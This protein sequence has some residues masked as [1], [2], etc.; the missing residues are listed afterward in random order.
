MT[1]ILQFYSPKFNQQVLI[2]PALKIFHSKAVAQILYA[3]KG[4][5]GIVDAA[6]K[7]DGQPF[8]FTFAPYV[9][10]SFDLSYKQI[11]LFSTSVDMTITICLRP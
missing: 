1:A 11:P 8:I 9:S 2:N 7:I 6:E 3:S 4:E 10:G 5:G